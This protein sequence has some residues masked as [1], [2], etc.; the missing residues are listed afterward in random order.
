VIAKGWADLDR[1][2]VLDASHQFPAPGIAVLVT[3][4]AVLRLIA[5]GGL[6]LDTPANEHLRT[7]RLADD[8]ITVRELLG[9]T[10]GGR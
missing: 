6:G 9:Y 1:A 7:V 5:D 10:A 4:T 2:E 8:T 3:A